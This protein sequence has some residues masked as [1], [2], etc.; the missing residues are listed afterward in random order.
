MFANIINNCLHLYK[1]S[2]QEK[3]KIKTPEN[4]KKA[5]RPQGEPTSVISVRIPTA[6]KKEVD[7]RFGIGWQGMFKDFIKVYLMDRDSSI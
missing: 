5:G 6:L 4:P 1:K 3:M 2:Q 7:E